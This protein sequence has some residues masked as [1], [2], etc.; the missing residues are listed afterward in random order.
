MFGFVFFIS[1]L[2]RSVRLC[3]DELFFW[4]F[5]CCVCRICGVGVMVCNGTKEVLTKKVVIKSQQCSIL[6]VYRL[7]FDVA[8]C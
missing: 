6:S 2:E 4:V 3:Y 1:E 8:K 7:G 5:Y